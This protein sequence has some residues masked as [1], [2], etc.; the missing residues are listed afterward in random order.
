LINYI[1][2]IQI[3]IAKN[4]QDEFTNKLTSSTLIA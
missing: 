1:D 3:Q 4:K 2:T